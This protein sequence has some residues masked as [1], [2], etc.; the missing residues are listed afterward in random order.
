[1]I[2][3]IY[4]LDGITKDEI[5]AFVM[6]L[7][8]IDKYDS[9]KQKI[10]NFREMVINKDKTK[11][12][13]KRIFD[14]IF[15]KEIINLYAN[16]IQS[17]EIKTRESKNKSIKNF[18]D[19]KKSNHKDYADAAIRYLRET[20]LFSIKSS[21][22]RKILIDQNKIDEVEFILQNVDRRPIYINEKQ[23]YKNYLFDPSFPQLLSDDKNA[24]IQS[25]LYQSSQYL[26]SDLI[27]KS[28]YDLKIIKLSIVQ[29]NLSVIKKNQVQELQTYKLFSDISEMY[30]DIEA[31]EL[32]DPSLFME[33]NTWRVFVM[34]DDGNVIGNF[35]LDDEG[36]PLFNA[37]GNMPDI[38][39][40]YDD[41]DLTVEVT[42]S[43]GATQYNS[44]SEP[45]ARHLGNHKKKTNKDSYCL[46]IAPKV[47]PATIA[48]FFGLY[49]IDIEFYGGKSKIIPLNL[50]DFSR[51]IKLANEKQEKPKASDIGKFIKKLH[52]SRWT[53]RT[54]YFGMNQ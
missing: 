36:M 27:S 4:E 22:S 24:L 31:K 1:M 32:I 49:K 33:W 20:K 54:K 48:H 42:L 11:T 45:V 17:G 2:R 18:T 3:L 34:L 43:S 53:Q 29:N 51:M 47:H 9:I 40:E 10:I 7:T 5:A 52:L 13:Y 35:G 8:S 12:N 44:E 30:R 6:Q 28:I 15:T 38:I 14:E 19:T 41:F 39:C 21:R 50:S 25:I 46:F 16:D 37:P 23:E 26:K